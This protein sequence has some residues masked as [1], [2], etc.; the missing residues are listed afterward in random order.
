M[1]SAAVKPPQPGDS[2]IS[3]ASIR[4]KLVRYVHSLEVIEDDEVEVAAEISA[5]LLKIAALTYEH[6]GR[7]L[8]AV[9]AKSHALLHGELRVLENLPPEMAQGLFAHPASYPVV[10]RVSTSPGD[11]LDDKVS[12]PR[13][14]A[15]KILQVHGTRLPGSENASTQ[16]FL[17]V[18][19]PA[20]I[21]PDARGFN[22][23]LKLLA[24]TTDKAEGAKK[25]L[26]AVLRGAE[27]LLEA[28]GA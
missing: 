8:R 4:A 3:S 5:T 6:G 12:T 17:M 20:F 25:V 11:I 27:K 28:I 10:L 24:S 16:Y 18:N 9:H 14:V 26:S 22:R 2:P 1:F 21:Q 19:A 7:G 23:S 15:M 13:G